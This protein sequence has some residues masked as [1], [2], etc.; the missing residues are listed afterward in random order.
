MKSL[1]IYRD[2]KKHI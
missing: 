1:Y 2:K